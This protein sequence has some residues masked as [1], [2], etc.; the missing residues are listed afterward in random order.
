MDKMLEGLEFFVGNVISDVNLEQKYKKK[1]TKEDLEQFKE[2]MKSYKSNNNKPIDFGGV[3]KIS[4]EIEKILVEKKINPSCYVG[5]NDSKE[6]LLEEGECFMDEDCGEDKKCVGR[7]NIIPGKC[8]D[9]SVDENDN[10]AYISHTNKCDTT[11]NC[12]IGYKCK[13]IPGILNNDK[14]CSTFILPKTKS[15]IILYELV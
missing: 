12:S 11:R 9:N 4:P 1:C 8:M 7:N 6:G 3:L 5:T 10:D 14:M 2:I 15:E 13:I